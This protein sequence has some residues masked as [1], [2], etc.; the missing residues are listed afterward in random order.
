[1]SIVHGV[2]KRVQQFPKQEI[3]KLS[4]SNLLLWKHQ[5]MLILERYGLQDYV[6]GFVTVPQFIVDTDAGSVVSDQ[7]QKYG[8]MD[9]FK[10]IESNSGSNRNYNQGHKHQFRD[11]KIYYHDRGRG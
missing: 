10:S 11:G 1:M 8:E 5:I 2:A 6:L 3:V 4:K 9:K 7:K